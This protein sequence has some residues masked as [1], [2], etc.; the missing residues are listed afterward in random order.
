MPSFDQMY[1][2]LKQW[3]KHDRF[4]GRNGDWC[5]NYSSIVTQSGLDHITKYGYGCISRHESVTGQ[6]I[7]FNKQLQDITN[8]DELVSLLRG[9]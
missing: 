4:E 5:P 6:A 7:F 3:Y 9:Y 8:T 1:A 2:F